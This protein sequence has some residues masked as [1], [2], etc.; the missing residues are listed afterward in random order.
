MKQNAL[1]DFGLPVRLAALAFG[2]ILAWPESGLGADLAVP[3]TVETAALASGPQVTAKAPLP[4]ILSKL[5]GARY[6]R[7]LAQQEMGKWREADREI[8]RLDDRLLLGHVLAQRYLHPTKYRS[9]YR[10]LH[11]WLARYAD[12]PDARRIY[13]LAM[14]RKPAKVRAPRR[15][16]RIRVAVGANKDDPRFPGYRSSKRRPAWQ[17]RWVRGKL[18]HI[19]YHARRRQPL[20][21]LKILNRHDVRR[22]FDSVETDISKAHIAEAYFRKGRDGKALALAG[23]AAKRSGFYVPRAS[24]T[25]GLAAYRAGKYA[26]AALYFEIL[27]K[28]KNLSPWY[29]A[30]GAFWA[31]RA[32][33]VAGNPAEVNHWLKDAA[34]HTRTFYGI[35]ARR[36]LGV[37]SPLSW[38]APTFGQNQL[39][40]MLKFPS[41][42]R[43]LALIQVGAQRRAER[44]LRLVAVNGDRALIE[45]LIVVAEHVNL[46]ALSY[47]AGLRLAALDGGRVRIR[48]LYP[49]PAWRPTGGYTVDRALVYAFIRQESAFKPRAKSHAGARGLM[50]LMPSTASYIGK[51]RYR[52]RRRAELYDPEINISLGQKY[53]DYL[54][55]HETVGPNLLLVAAAYNGGPG[56]L[57]KWRRRSSA[58][59]DPL[60][61]MET[62]PARE[63]RNFVRRVL[64]NL[65]LYRERLGQKSPSLDAIAAGA[66][67]HYV[68][69]DEK[70]GRI[71]D[72]VRN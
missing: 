31:A 20:T 45:A 27:T 29:V 35:L 42:K 19:R 68:R 16:G 5:D 72:N 7:I 8:A 57:A 48:A 32:H 43:A 34:R 65:W 38:D 53:L 15:P 52:G 71:A 11:N 47:K 58:G 30:G 41:A 26:E 55:R 17:K 46:P 33:L 1:N 56:N 59:N 40:A 13:R 4:D 25:A 66:W 70:L 64:A 61:F 28:A 54:M 6:G 23:P 14:R 62:I 69:L 36:L 63:T 50:Q 9:R 3:S 21:A 2:A 22:R 60:L 24:W 51:R 37:E 39:A 10:E 18:R 44:E 12:H 67:P 49:V